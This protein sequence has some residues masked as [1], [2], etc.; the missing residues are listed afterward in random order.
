MNFSKMYGI[1]HV[2]ST[3]RA[4]STAFDGEHRRSLSEHILRSYAC[5]FL[6]DDTACG[7]CS[8]DPLRGSLFTCRRSPRL[9]SNGYYVL[10]EDSFLSDE[11]GNIT[12]TPSQ[13]SVTYKEN[14]VRI[15][16]RKKK[17]RRSL[18]SLFSLSASSSWLSS[19]VLSNT[20]SSHG[21]DPWSDG[22]SKLEASQADIG[23]SDFSSEYDSHVPQGQTP[24]SLGASL[25]KD[26]EFIQPGKPFCAS[27]S[28]S[29]FIINANEETLIKAEKQNSTVRNVLAQMAA[30]V[31]CLIISICTR[32]FLGGLSATLLLI[33]LV[34]LL[35][36]DAA[37]SSFFGLV[38]SFKTAK[39][40]NN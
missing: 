24:A 3:P 8:T 33:I 9:L 40:W 31:L 19:T 27:A 4:S 34:F 21:D 11:E 12:L 16:R 32:Y 5:A 1:S 20:E 10:T 7:Y 37:L 35:S 18:A 36:Q 14:L 25:T 22:C 2:A 38:T 26:E 30:L 23:D 29:Q 28:C 17:I 6:A 13:T 39:F 15:F